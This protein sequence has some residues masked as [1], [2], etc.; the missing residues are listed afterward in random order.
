MTNY[1]T[2]KTDWKI[3]KIARTTKF[4]LNEN[5]KRPKMIRYSKSK[6]NR[7]Q[8]NKIFKLP[9]SNLKKR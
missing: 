1:N 8:I 5:F 6:Q 7:R 9:K 2:R 3:G 4:K